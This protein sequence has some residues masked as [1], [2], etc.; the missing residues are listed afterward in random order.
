MQNLKNTT[1]MLRALIKRD[2][3]KLLIWVVAV[4]GY[5]ASGASKFENAVNSPAT[6]AS[7]KAMF[8][9][10]A[11]TGLFGPNLAPKGSSFG[12]A[13]LFS[14]TMGL[15][16]VIV[17][18]IVAVIYVINRTRGDE[19][20]GIAELFR[21][22][23]VG[24]LATTTAVVIETFILQLVIS[25]VLGMSLYAQQ[26]TGMTSLSSNLLY[27]FTIG[28]Q[29]FL[30]GI[31]ALV[32]AQ[33][34]VE[35]GSAKGAT[36]GLMGLLYIIR[37]G[38]DIKNPMAGAWNPLTWSYL[39]KVYN[40][41][42]TWW[43]VV[44]ST[45]L[46]LTLVVVAYLL[47]THRD[48][49]AGYVQA[50]QGKDHAPKSLLSIPGL[51]LR[52]QRN[53]ILGWLAGILLLGFVYGSM[54]GQMG[55]FIS[56][57]STYIAIFQI[58]G[59]TAK[60]EIQSFAGTIYM[61]IAIFTACLVITSFIRM[62]GEERKSRLEQIYALPVSRVGIFLTY[63]VTATVLGIIGQFIGGLGVYLAQAGNKTSI[64]LNFGQVMGP[65]MVW[66]F[67]IFFILS[68]LALL[69]A[70]LPRLSALIWVYIGLIFFLS[71]F[72][73]LL[74]LPKALLHLNIFYYIP[75]LPVDKLVWSTLILVLVIAVALKVVSL[76][77]YRGRDLISG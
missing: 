75:R 56:S 34:F 70:F 76:W 30:W 53:A 1:G 37:M 5:V 42:E 21:S 15:L 24:K 11:M 74:K 16:T 61:V 31:V 67:A 68:L 60:Q 50:G 73:S 45:L 52:Q 2:W 35:A 8:A 26:I 12:L 32:F 18:S 33:L 49:N 57:N 48:T 7:M 6:A 44:A 19:E 64:L 58:T 65:A 41:N 9:N 3:I 38:T 51:V 63:I 69:Q 54:F 40:S 66:V 29:G 28:A 43:P 25:L 72:G 47:E 13:Q 10:P 17:F 46:A 36:F 4:V 71:L 62:T 39:T 20:T 55:S 59:T 77:R 14:Q 23:Q 22:F 27:G